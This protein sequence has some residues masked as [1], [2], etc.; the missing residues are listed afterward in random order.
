MLEIMAA[1]QTLISVGDYLAHETKPASEYE[2]GVLR[3]K[4]KA[5]WDHG[6]LQKRIMQL[7]DHAAPALVS[8]SE[9]T[10][11]IREGKFLVPD[12]I[13]QRREAIQDPYPLEPVHLCVEILSP[14]DRMRSA[15]EVRG[16]PR[17]G[18]RDDVDPRSRRAPRLAVP[19]ATPP[20]GSSSGRKSGNRR[21]FDSLGRSLCSAG[22][23]KLKCIAGVP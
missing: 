19:E 10:V 1:V 6:V 3:Q 5:A 16:V 15:G 23:A 4:P 20:R 18:S 11:Q 22:L 13:A 8:A 9:V 2:D 14:S 17:L 21:C 12:V 7:L